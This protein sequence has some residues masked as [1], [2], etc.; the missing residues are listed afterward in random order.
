MYQ[1]TALA[2]RVTP[3]KVWFVKIQICRDFNSF[4]NTALRFASSA[5]RVCD[6]PLIPAPSLFDR[7]SLPLTAQ[8]SA[9]ESCPPSATFDSQTK[10]SKRLDSVTL[11]AC[12]G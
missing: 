6:A 9:G 4:H 7:S 1:C 12:P 11:I 8:P 5:I 10:R 2:T 3:G